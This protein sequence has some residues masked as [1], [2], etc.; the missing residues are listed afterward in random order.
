MKKLTKILALGCLGLLALASCKKSDSL[1]T[2]TGGKAG[3]LSTN[4]S[5]LVLDKAKV[6]SPDTV[7]TFNFNQASY[8]YKAAVT[9]TLQIDSMGDN[10]T[11][12][13][14]K[15]VVL[16]PNVLKVGYTTADFNSILLKL[17]LKSGVS[18]QIQIRV[19]QS[20]SSNVKPVYSNVV[21]LTVTPFNLTSWLYVPGSY[22]G[23]ANSTPQMDSLVSV[24]GNGIYVGIIN[25]T[26]GNND[27]LVLPVKGSWTHKY[28]TNDPKNSTSSTVTYDGPNNFYAPATA[29]QYIVTFNLNTNTI[30]FALADYYSIIGSAPPGNAWST[31]T[32]M[33]YVNDGAGNWVANNIPMVVGEYKF[34]Q[35]AQWSNSW[36]P[37]ATAGTVVSSGAVG[38]GNIQLTTAGNYNFTLHMPATSYG[39]TPLATTT[40]TATKQ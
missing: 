21:N 17:N 5:E 24:T 30:S 26:A 29:G 11:A 2:S 6:S 38:D 15:S 36:G 18:S 31:D 4:V 1:V 8:G 14:V 34:R 9:N 19:A 22:E 10:W 27:F 3:A 20:I 25:F 28:A 39:S 12:G 35:D 37:S 7:I 16:A 33:K 32:F 13:K 40:F 23:W